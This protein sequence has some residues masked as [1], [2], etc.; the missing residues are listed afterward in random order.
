MRS[1]VGR[2][3]QKAA[4]VAVVELTRAGGCPILPALRANFRRLRFTIPP[5]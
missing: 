3:S 4:G 1:R 5:K 2:A